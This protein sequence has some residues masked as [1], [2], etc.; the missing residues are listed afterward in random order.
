MPSFASFRVLGSL[1]HFLVDAPRQTVETRSDAI[2][3]L[4]EGVV[5]VLDDIYRNPTYSTQS[6][7]A[8]KGS[9]KKSSNTRTMASMSNVPK[10]KIY[11]IL[12]I[13]T[14]SNAQEAILLKERLVS[15]A[16]RALSVGS[17]LE[18]TNKASTNL[19]V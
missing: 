10:D 16:R 6:K 18:I 5:Q 1:H 11:Q 12:G 4:A 15:D 9:S 2:H 17:L 8:G 13:K 14:P 3:R 7:S 19:R